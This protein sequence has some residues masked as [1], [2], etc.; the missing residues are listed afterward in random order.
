MK[1]SFQQITDRSCPATIPNTFRLIAQNHGRSETC[2]SG[3]GGM[4]V[5][6]TYFKLTPAPYEKAQTSEEM[7]YMQAVRSSRQLSTEVLRMSAWFLSSSI[8][9]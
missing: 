2:H 9:V 8:V 6:H 5:L 1:R 4:L 3:C 7:I